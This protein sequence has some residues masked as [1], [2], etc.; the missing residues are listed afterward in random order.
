MKLMK[1]CFLI[2]GL[3]LS[4]GAGA[5]TYYEH[6]NSDAFWSQLVLDPSGTV[7]QVTTSDT[8]IV[9]ASNRALQPGDLR[10]ISELQDKGIVRYYFV[11]SSGGRWHV[12]PRASLSGALALLP[13]RNK[14]WIVYTEGM[15]KIFTSDIDR[16]MRVAGEYGIN[17]L[18]LDY[19]S[20]RSTYKSIKN[21][22]F[23]MHHA[24][25]AYNDFVPVLDSFKLL[26]VQRKLGDGSLTL[27]FH[28]MGNYLI[29]EIVRN[30]LLFKF[31]NTVWVDNL[32]L[33]APCVPRRGHRKWIDQIAFAKR[34]YVHYNPED[35]T[36]KWARIAG[37]RQILG[38]HAK[39]PLSSKAVYVN[40]NTLTG[41]GHSN[42]MTL[43]GRGPAPGESMDHFRLLF[44]GKGV[45]V[46]D[47]NRYRPSTYRGVGYDILPVQ[48]LQSR[49]D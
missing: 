7:P 8:A 38:E 19:P 48:V 4:L 30:N 11:Y 25:I 36:L 39:R 31:N 49:K 2:A 40:F 32:L 5:Q 33:N 17:V 29:R 44:H 46:Q 45:D 23:A 37:F 14:D 35:G 26:R 18:L 34:I 15:G 24:K 22:K 21:Y 1:T 27:F 43:W 42:F 16:G 6:F 28:S 12:L 3:L 20:I 10:F 41:R 47:R 13:D 9:V